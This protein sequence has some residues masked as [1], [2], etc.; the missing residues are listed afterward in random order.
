MAATEAAVGEVKKQHTVQIVESHMSSEFETDAISISTEALDKSSHLKD[1]AQTIKQGYDKKHPGS[2][3]AT[4]GVF[5]CIVGKSF[6][7]CVAHETRMYVHLKID[8]MHVV[9]WK[10][11]DSPFHAGEG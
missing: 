4:E 8:M 9:I 10:S 2:G 11:K 1:I 7:S 3:K 6:G 5:H